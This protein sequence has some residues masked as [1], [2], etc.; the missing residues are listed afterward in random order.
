ME[1][2]GCFGGYNRNYAACDVIIAF[3]I[4]PVELDPHYISAAAQD[5]APEDTLSAHTPMFANHC[6]HKPSCAAPLFTQRL[7]SVVPVLLGL[8]WTTVHVRSFCTVPISNLQALRSSQRSDSGSSS[9]DIYSVSMSTNASPEVRASSQWE[10]MW[11]SGLKKGDM[12]DTGVV[13]P[14][15]QKLLDE[16]S[17]SVY[18]GVSFAQTKRTSSCSNVQHR[19]INTVRSSTGTDMIV[20]SEL[21]SIGP[22]YRWVRES[23]VEP[24]RLHA[25]LP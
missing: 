24:T 22:V 8:A 21:R 9:R 17:P 19:R 3:E 1:S 4:G 18:V 12:F 20:T 25:R 23:L 5:S 16:G 7:S 2:T 11:S 13:S 10:G 14:A 15:L 6:H